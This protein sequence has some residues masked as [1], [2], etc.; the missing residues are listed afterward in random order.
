M[1][2]KKNKTKNITRKANSIKLSISSIANIVTKSHVTTPTYMCDG[3]M[4]IGK[5]GFSATTTKQNKESAWLYGFSDRGNDSDRYGI[6]I[7]CKEWLG[8]EGGVSTEMNLYVGAQVT[9]W[10][11]AEVS[12][13]FDG[14][15]GVV[16][17]DIEDTSYDF[18]IKGGWGTIVAA[19][20]T[21]LGAN[22]E[23]LVRIM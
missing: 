22:P 5:V 1:K 9:P 17:V 10:I 23:V 2:T 7:N 11:H 6:G 21:A 3:G 8:V 15:G 18:E 16:G 4:L 20:A 19:G 14:L 13:G 12:F